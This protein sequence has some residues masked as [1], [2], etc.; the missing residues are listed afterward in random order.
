MMAAVQAFN[1]PMVKFRAKNFAVLANI[2]WTNVL[3]E[4]YE[5]KGVGI[6]QGD[7]TLALSQMI[8]RPDCPLEKPEK[9]NIKALQKIRDLVEH[10]YWIEADSEFISIFQANCLNFDDFLSTN[11][12]NQTALSNE[13]GLALQ[14]ANMNFGQIATLNQYAL[15]HEITALSD[16]LY[17]GPSDAIKDSTKYAFNVV[18]ALT[19][20]SKGQAHFQFL[21]PESHE[22]QEIHNILVKN[23]PA[24]DMYPH[25]PGGVC[26]KVEQ[27]TRQRFNMHDHTTAWKNHG[28]RPA[29]SSSAPD[30]TN[31]EFCHYS[32]AHRNYL[33]NDKWVKKLVDEVNAK[34]T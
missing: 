28:V 6:W 26:K 31:S 10:K 5:R 2:A 33:Y 7:Q 17:D 13:M 9:E 30:T 34:K 20:A 16:E 27:A 11:F 23:V 25:M 1:N 3:H 22:G 8:K 32:V 14:F 18:Y 24:P 21:G 4:Y 12:E 29:W 19:A 15:P